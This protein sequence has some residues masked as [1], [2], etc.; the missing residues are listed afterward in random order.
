MTHFDGKTTLSAHS[1]INVVGR[2]SVLEPINLQ[3]NVP[4]GATVLSIVG[5]D[6]SD[7]VRVVLEGQF[8]PRD[9]WGL[10]KPK[11]N[12]TMVVS[13][14]P[15]GGNIGDALM[16]VAMI[17][18]T[19]YAPYAANYVWGVSSILTGSVVVGGII[20]AGIFLAGGA[21]IASFLTSD[22]S[23]PY[24]DNDQP[25]QYN[26]ITSTNNRPNPYGLVPKLFGFNWVVPPLAALPFTEVRG[27]DEQYVYSLMA[28][29]Y[30]NL[31]VAGLERLYT[32]GLATVSKSE[33]QVTKSHSALDLSLIKIGETAIEEFDDFEIEIGYKDDVTLFVD[34]IYEDRVSVVY[35]KDNE[36]L[37]TVRTTVPEADEASID[38]TFAQGCYTMS[39]KGSKGEAGY[40]IGYLVDQDLNDTMYVL[41]Q[42]VDGIVSVIGNKIYFNPRFGDYTDEFT[43]RTL[44]ELSTITDYTYTVSVVNGELDSMTKNGSN[45]IGFSV[46]NVLNEGDGVAIKIEYAPTG[47][48]SWTVSKESFIS[49]GT[50]DPFANSFDIKFPSRGQYDIKLTRVSTTAKYT[51]YVFMDFSWTT[52][53]SVTT[54]QNFNIDNTLLMAIRMKAT[55]QLNGNLDN[56]SVYTQSLLPN[57]DENGLTG[58]YTVGNNAASCYLEAMTGVQNLHVID[59]SRIDF[60]KLKNWYDWCELNNITYNWVH[61]KDETLPQRLRIISAAGFGK[62]DIEADKFTVI[63]DVQQP[64]SHVITPRNSNGFSATKQFID[65]PHAFRVEFINPDINQKDEIIVYNDGYD[66]TNATKFEVLTTQGI[67]NHEHAWKFGRYHLAQVKLRPE[68]Y[69]VD[70]DIESITYTNGDTVKL[71]YDTMLVSLHWGRIKSMTATELTLDER[72]VIEA[73]KTYSMLVRKQDGTTVTFNVSGDPSETNIVDW[74]QVAGVNDGDLFSFGESDKVSIDAKVTNITRAGDYNATVTMVDAAH[75]IFDAWTGVIPDFETGI[76]VPPSLR[77]PSPPLFSVLESDIDNFVRNPDNSYSSTIDVGW[78]I[79]SSA[80]PVERVEI[81]YAEILT[82]D[83]SLIESGKY[84]KGVVRKV[85]VGSNDTQLYV[86]GQNIESGSYY[87]VELVAVSETGKYSRNNPKKTVKAFDILDYVDVNARPT[88]NDVQSGTDHLLRQAD[89]TIVSRVFVDWGS[90]ATKIEPFNYNVSFKRETDVE[91]Q[92][93]VVPG[94]TTETHLSPLND[95]VSYDIRVRAF[96]VIGVYS[97]CACT[98]HIVIGKTEPPSDVTVGQVSVVDRHLSVSWDAVTDPDIREYELRKGPT[99][100]TALFIDRIK[101]TSWDRPADIIGDHTW[102]VKAID[103]SGLY[104]DNAKALSINIVKPSTPVVTAEVID[105]NVLLKFVSQVGTIPIESYEIERGGEIVGESASNFHLLFENSGGLYTYNVTA[106]DVAG[107]RSDVGSFTANVAQPPDYVLNVKFDSEF[108]GTKVNCLEDNGKLIAPVSLDE[109][110]SD[111]LANGYSTIQ[112][113]LDVG[114]TNWLEGQGLTTASYT[115]EYD[116]GAILPATLINLTPS[117]LRVTG[118]VTVAPTIEVSADGVIWITYVD[119]WSVYATNFR[120]LRFTIDITTSGDINDQVIFD[121]LEVK[122]DSK[123]KNDAGKGTITNAATGSLQTFNVDFIDI[124]SIVPTALY[125]GTATN[126][127][128]DFLDEANPT[129]FTVYLLDETNTKTTGDFSW[130]ARGY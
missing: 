47:T 36:P 83:V 6:A 76:T 96:Y 55:D 69:N 54:G 92:T 107:N 70:L 115:E 110:W 71:T 53:R 126:A 1:G 73:G 16:V 105:N 45:Y 86:L 104:S 66:I 102:L 62:F 117:Y 116:Y 29:G 12:T 50:K 2:P 84:T 80:T 24:S 123:L 111:Y 39:D 127:I 57:F 64:Y 78:L 106:I 13:R 32:D 11:S 67:S 87:E 114:F 38:V 15:H 26:A 125:G 52:L 128:V 90:P 89:G 14:T 28:I 99:W 3:A 4:V 44:N 119:N 129:E 60:Y 5:K 88:I 33:G 61:S 72:V 41:N 121:R 37:S 34:D 35:E 8:I 25:D 22:V 10:V 93:L 91:W 17:A 103:T 108:L 113:E 58:G 20:T 63:R 48:E 118:T 68:T 42:V 95:G 21:L 122:L 46:E 82:T 7:D 27:G 112:D 18:I 51:D 77:E 81:R 59:E 19:V 94:D 9:K 49:G 120:Y 31:K 43:I 40:N 97:E 79:Q 85:S 30:G 65:I 23:D 74:T 75:D 130:I 109:L 100:D 124:I 56:V 101:T 98:T